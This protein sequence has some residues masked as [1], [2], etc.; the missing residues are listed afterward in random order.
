MA[1]A[2]KVEPFIASAPPY[3]PSSQSGALSPPATPHAYPPAPSSASGSRAGSSTGRTLSVVNDTSGGAALTPA[4]RK[5][6]E[7][8]RS[9]SE[10][11]AAAVQYHAD[12]GVRFDEHGRPIE[13]SASTSTREPLPLADVPP[14]YTPS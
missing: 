14:E 5:V 6:A 8:Q 10:A 3:T 12:S 2:A 9:Q 1:Q 11:E 4:Q 7:A 13:A